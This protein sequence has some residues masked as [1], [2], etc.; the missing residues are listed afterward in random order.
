MAN[1]TVLAREKLRPYVEIAEFRE[2]LKEQV[3]KWETWYRAHTE[4]I[5]D[6]EGLRDNLHRELKDLQGSEFC[7]S[8]D[9]A[10]FDPSGHAETCYENYRD[11]AAGLKDD[12]EYKL[13]ADREPVLFKEAS[14]ASIVALFWCDVND[15]TLLVPEYDFFGPEGS[16]IEY[17]RE[18]WEKPIQKRYKHIDWYVEAAIDA[19]QSKIAGG[20]VSRSTTIENPT[21]TDD[22]LPEMIDESPP[23]KYDPNSADWILSETLCKVIKIKA[24]TIADYRKARKCGEDKKDEFGSWN[25]DCVG[26]FRR[27]V[28]G[29]GSVAYYRPAMSESYKAKLM[30]AESQKLQKP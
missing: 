30:Y 21:E 14:V 27:K 13:V 19:Y 4:E 5:N 6:F 12:P 18:Q 9:P 16:F 22:K 24:D 11:I 29:K 17:L 2:Y 26:K 1:D 8:D 3:L 15:S 7:H 10:D 23:P 28:N 20:L 25:V